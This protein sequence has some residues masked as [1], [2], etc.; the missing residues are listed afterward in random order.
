MIYNKYL[1]HYLH[2]LNFSYNFSMLLQLHLQLKE[3]QKRSDKLVKVLFDTKG[4]SN[5]TRKVG[6]GGEDT[7]KL[8][9]PLDNSSLNKLLIS[10]HLHR[11]Y[12]PAMVG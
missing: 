3:N 10:H 1:L 11:Y 7:L 2:Y 4:L 8:D 5:E 12:V 9:K 6:S